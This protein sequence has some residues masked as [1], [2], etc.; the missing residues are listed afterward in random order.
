ME[1]EFFFNFY[2]N[3]MSRQNILDFRKKG[4]KKRRVILPENKFMTIY[5]VLNM[6]FV[7]NKT[8]GCLKYR[9]LLKDQR[10]QENFLAVVSQKSTQSYS[11]NL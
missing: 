3:D 10:G 1:Y 5:N 7:H 8:S 2:F 6:S 4:K 9:K 11:I